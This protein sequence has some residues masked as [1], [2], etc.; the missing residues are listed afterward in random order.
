MIINLKFKRQKFFLIFYFLLFIFYFCTFNFV[1]AVTVGPAKI[2]YKVNPGEKI[3]DKLFL[4]NET[5][6]T[7]TYY[8]S[9][10]KFTIEN[11]EMKFLS[12]EPTEL[13]NWFKME[14]S[15]TLKPKEQKEIPF[16]IEIPPDAPPG[17]HFAVIW[18]GTGAPTK[19]AGQVGVVARAGILVFL[20]VSGQVNE[21]GS[22]VEFSLPGKK[23]IVFKFPE[24]FL[25][26]FKNEGNTYL[27]PK[28]EIVVKNIFGAKIAYYDVNTKDAIVFP[29]NTRDLNV[30]K[31]FNQP[32]LGF[33]LYRA[34]L[35]LNWG[36]NQKAEKTIYFVALNWFVLIAIL[37]IIFVL[38]LLPKAIRK[39]NQYIIEKYSQ[40]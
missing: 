23:F 3:S 19:E 33:G 1:F 10:E 30:L 21:K 13:P 31:K 5:E 22:I 15:V 25:L 12:G 32:P 7:Q 27:K 17:G 16:T 20:Q 29:N 26:K 37:L 6:Q 8:A 28:G 14:R 2:E 4:Y 35:N 34:V 18:W 39:Y 38:F 36:E 24:E 40:K 11:N 9:F